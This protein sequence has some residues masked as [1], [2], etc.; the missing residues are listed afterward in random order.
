M[1]DESHKTNRRE[2]LKGALAAGTLAGLT[3]QV[4]FAGEASPA[5]KA[6]R[7]PELIRVENEKPGTKDWMLANTRVDPKT[8]YRCPWIEGYCSHTSIRAGEQLKIMVSTNPASPFTIDVYRL[9]YYD[10]NGGRHMKQFG[11]LAGRFSPIRISPM[12]GSANA[13][14]SLHSSLQFRPIGPAA[15]IS[16]S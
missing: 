6:A 1:P 4:V 2:L 8:K 7:V 10:G 16:A 11:P 13:D 3:P 12:S 15:C 14:G 5:A 9:G